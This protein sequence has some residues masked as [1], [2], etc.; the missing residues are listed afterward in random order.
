MWWNHWLFFFVI[1]GFFFKEIS[2]RSKVPIGSSSF[3]FFLLKFFTLRSTGGGPG[4]SKAAA[5]AD[6]K[7]ERKKERKKD[8]IRVLVGSGKR[9][10]RRGERN[11]K[12]ERERERSR[13]SGSRLD[14]DDKA[15]KVP[16]KKTNEKVCR[17]NGRGVCPVAIG[18]LD[19]H[20]L[21][22]THF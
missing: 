10:A 22:N 5:A 11:K 16:K 7:N 14:V 15:P 8:E 13:V 17:A 4:T 2:V 21:T 6:R 20:W 1:L 3:S 9:K 19:R 12:R 18:S